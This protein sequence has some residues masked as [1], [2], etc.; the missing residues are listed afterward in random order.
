VKHYDDRR[1]KLEASRSVS[2]TVRRGARVRTRVEAPGE[3]EGPL[4]AGRRVGTA[5]VLVNGKPAARVPLV[6]ASSVPEA[7]FIRRSGQA[8]GWAVAFVVL[9]AAALVTLRYRGAR[10]RRGGGVAT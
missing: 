4:P 5:I 7:G 2:L 10:S 9:A 1:V 6:T 3:L 8:V